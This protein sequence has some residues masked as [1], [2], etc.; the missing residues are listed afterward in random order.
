M[1]S[2][3]QYLLEP[4]G[5]TGMDEPRLRDYSQL[6]KLRVSTSVFRREGYAVAIFD[7]VHAG[8]K[9][10]YLCHGLKMLR[11]QSFACIGVTATPMMTSP[12]VSSLLLLF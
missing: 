4:P 6:A 7:E 2:D 5:T 9:P 11:K 10:G 1:A 8:R 3:A 12:V